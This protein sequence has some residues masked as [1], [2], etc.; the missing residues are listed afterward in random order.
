VRPGRRALLWLALA[1]PVA[2][3]EKLFSPKSPFNGIDVTGSNMG[4]ELRLADHNGKARALAE[5]RGKAVVVV[6]GFTHCPDVCPTALSDLASAV[7]A[8]GPDGARVQVLFVTVDPK[9]DRPELMRQYVPAFH[10][11]FLGLTGDEESL[12]KVRKD[13]NVYAAIREGTSPDNYSVDHT[14]QMF[15][16][17]P[18][19]RIRLVWSPGALPKQIADDLRVLL[20]S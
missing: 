9:R 3:C 8:L 13:F 7:K 11:G 19:G 1:A 6:F 17:D 4:G 20:N 14:A 2:G 15:G 16:F 5:F 12:A 10:P 18:E